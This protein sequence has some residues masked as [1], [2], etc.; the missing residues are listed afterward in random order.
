METAPFF[1]TVM[2]GPPDGRAVWLTTS[3][4]VRIRAGL[5]P[6]GTR[7]T[8][9]IFPGR[10]EYVEKYSDAARHFQAAGLASVTVDWR[11]QGLTTRPQHDRMLGHVN[12]YSEFQR[13][14]DAL[15]ALC[16]SEDLPRPY[17]LL[18]HSMGGLI[19]LGAVQDR[20]DFAR[21]VFSSPLWGLPLPPHMRILA[22]T[23][24]S[25]AAMLRMGEQGAPASGKN[26][27]PAGQPFEGN[28]LTNDPEMFAWMKRQITEHPD[29]ALGAP[30]L[31]WLWATFR[32]MH[33]RARQ[34]APAI[35]CL[36]LLG[37]DED[38]VDPDAI[39]VR[40][41]S[42]PGSRLEMVPGGRHET[43]MEDA[44]TRGRLYD[45]IIAHFLD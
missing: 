40:M 6:E 8:V 7:G 13:D 44:A 43:L 22:L 3:D 17:Y 28:L 29:L 35:P 4:G 20:T 23:L 39:H 10:T 2:D 24:S 32:E 16:G 27:D 21:V 26:A 36:T 18:A 5:W 25:A 19:G 33:H 15:L 41:G 42:W 34:A 1:E 45:Q 11:G 31:G 37:S 30:T 9:L 12:N 14:V 38:I